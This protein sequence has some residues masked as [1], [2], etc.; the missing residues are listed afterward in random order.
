MPRPTKFHDDVIVLDRAQQV[1]WERGWAAPSI[2]EIEAAVELKAPSIYRRFGDKAGLEVAVLDHYL[3]RV[4]DRRIDRYLSPLA[5][6]GENVRRFLESAVAERP[7]SQPAGCLLIMATAAVAGQPHLAPG[8]GRG[9]ARIEVAL[10]REV[11]RLVGEGR[12]DPRSA[13]A[14]VDR[15]LVGFVGLMGL[16]RA[17]EEA[18]VLQRRAASLLAGVG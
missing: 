15:I 1:Y 16:A 18:P 4:V 12:A 8:V 2:R 3:D 9:L 11:G 5:D 14:F 10:A 17:G 7:A 6:P 13:D